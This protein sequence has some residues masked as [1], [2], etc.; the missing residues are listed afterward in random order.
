MLWSICL[1]LLTYS[2]KAHIFA[3]AVKE[4]CG[5]FQSGRLEQYSQSRQAKKEIFYQLETVLHIYL[6]PNL[7]TPTKQNI[8]LGVTPLRFAH[9]LCSGRTS[10]LGGVIRSV[11]HVQHP[12]GSN[13]FSFRL[14]LHWLKLMGLSHDE[15]TTQTQTHVR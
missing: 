9:M 13:Q 12:I 3:Y 6:A 5:D 10:R 14:R 8:E 4:Q 15:R 1:N 2:H 7:A 11:A